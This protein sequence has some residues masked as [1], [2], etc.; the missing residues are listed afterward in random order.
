MGG[1]KTVVSK[2]TTSSSNFNMYACDLGG[3]V[4]KNIASILWPV[5]IFRIG[6]NIDMC[7]QNGPNWV[8]FAS[9]ISKKVFDPKLIKI[10]LI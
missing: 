3:L 5:D 1:R 6:V 9:E 4:F 10:I 2:K 7:S 8:R